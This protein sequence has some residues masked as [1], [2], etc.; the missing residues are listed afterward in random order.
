MVT[1]SFA[2]S[3]EE[4]STRNFYQAEKEYLEYYPWYG[5][6]NGMRMFAAENWDHYGAL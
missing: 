1:A 4:N 3:I 6:N 2:F 5:P